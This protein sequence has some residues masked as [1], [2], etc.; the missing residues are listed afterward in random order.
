MLKTNQ[1]IN[2]LFQIVHL[3]I[4]MAL[5][6]L[7]ITQFFDVISTPNPLYALQVPPICLVE[8][9]CKLMQTEYFIFKLKA[10]N[11]N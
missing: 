1:Q 5:K 2:Q 10:N 9:S 11:S 8:L 7:L 3:Q 4:L 6:V